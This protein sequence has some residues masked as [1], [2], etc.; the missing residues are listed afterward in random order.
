MRFEL[1]C[2]ELENLGGWVSGFGSFGEARAEA[3]RIERRAKSRSRFLGHPDSRGVILWPDD[4]EILGTSEEFAEPWSCP[5]CGSDRPA[6][7]VEMASDRSRV[8]ICSKCSM[9]LEW[10]DSPDRLHLSNIDLDRLEARDLE[11]EWGLEVS[12]STERIFHLNDPVP[13]PAVHALTHIWLPPYLTSRLVSCHEKDEFGYG[14]GIY[15]ASDKE[16]LVILIETDVRQDGWLGYFVDFG[17]L[18]E[19]MK[20]KRRWDYNRPWLEQLP[21]PR[22]FHFARQSPYR[23]EDELQGWDI[24]EVLTNA[25]YPFD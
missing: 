16:R 22:T 21:D 23:C 7:K 12:V 9:P 25:G 8:W 2:F 4:W 18:N 13:L 6:Y 15:F 11:R 24:L 14:Y 19:M 3:E 10:R 5:K 17:S 1:T 20:L